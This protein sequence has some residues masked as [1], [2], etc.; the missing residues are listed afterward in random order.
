MKTREKTYK[1]NQNKLDSY[2]LPAKIISWEFIKKMLIALL[3]GK[4]S[5]KGEHG[6]NNSRNNEAEPIN[7]S[8]EA[9]RACYRA[10]HVSSTLCTMQYG[11]IVPRMLQQLAAPIQLYL[12]SVRLSKVRQQRFSSVRP[13]VAGEAKC[14]Y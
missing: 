12:A 14:T 3:V 4:W 2:K 8:I 7:S 13:F 11:V 5:L 9:S 1:K 6:K 10:Y